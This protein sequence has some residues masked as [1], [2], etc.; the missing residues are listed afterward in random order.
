MITEGRTQGWLRNSLTDFHSWA[1]FNGARLD[2][3]R[4]GLI[5]GSELKGASVSATRELSQT[6]NQNLITVPRDLVLCL[7]KVEEFAKSDKHLREVL[8]A[9]G[10]FGRVRLLPTNSALI[11]GMERK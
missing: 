4:V 5:K 11:V 9:L 6:P 8:Q 1:T 2:G 3:V 10:D 7:E